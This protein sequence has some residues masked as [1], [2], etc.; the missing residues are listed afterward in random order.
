MAPPTSG[1]RG[2]LSVDLDKTHL[3]HNTSAFALI[4]L[5]NSL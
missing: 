1:L 4:V 2:R 3:E 5:Q